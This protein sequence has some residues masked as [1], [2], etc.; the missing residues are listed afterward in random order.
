MIKHIT[1]DDL[2]RMNDREGLILQGCGGDPQ[3][4]LD[5]INDLFAKEDILS[6]GS[7][8]RDM[9]VFVQDGHTNLLFHMDDVDLDVGKLAAW[10]LQTRENF[11]GTWLSDFVPNQLNGFVSETQEKQLPDC[12]IIGAD[13][14]VFNLI[15]IASR[16][17][18]QNGMSAQAKEMSERAFV[19]GSYDAALGVIMEYVN[20]V[21]AEDRM[22]EDDDEDWCREPECDEDQGF[23][24]MSM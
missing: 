15:G 13:G 9:S 17:L 18:K 22:D 19:G 10:R 4:W 7:R 8:F 3:E 1:T 20:P 12:P 23:G 2:R 24:G 16:T 11:G 6:A 14:N 21:S 5:G